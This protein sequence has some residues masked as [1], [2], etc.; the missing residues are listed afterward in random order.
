MKDK[1]KFSICVITKNESKTLPR[2]VKSLKEF[3]E[4]GGEIVVVDTG[5]TDNTAQLARDLGCTTYEVGTKFITVLDKQTAQDINTRFIVD[6]EEPVVA[7]GKKFFDFSAARNYCTSLAS[8]DV[9]SYADADEIFTAMNIDYLNHLIKVGVEQFE[10]NFVYAHDAYGN[11]AIKFIQ[12]KMYDRR[13]CKWV[14]M[15]HEVL[16]GEAHRTQLPEEMFKLEHYQIPSEHRGNYLSGLALDCFKNQD[17]DRNSHYFARE[18]MWCGRPKSAIKEFERHVA[19]NRWQTEKAQSII[20]I[21]DCCGMLRQPEKQVEY[22]NKAIYA[23]GSRREPYIKLA[24]FYKA[25]N[26]HLLTAVYAMAAT[27]IPWGSYYA[28]DK[29]MY[30]Q[31]P[32][33]LLYW[34]KGWLGDIKGAQEHL[35]EALKYQPHNPKFLEDTKYYFEYWDH[36]IQGYMKFPELLF[37][38]EEAKK[39]KT[40]VEIGSFQ[41]RS[42]HALC[43]G[44]KGVVTAVD[45]FEGSAEVHDGTHGMKGIYEI[46]KENTKGFDNL[47]VKKTDSLSGAKDFVDKSIDMVFIDAEHSYEAVKKDIEAWLPKTK[48]VLCGHDYCDA[49]PGVMRAVDEVFGKPDKVVDSIWVKYL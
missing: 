47:S 39:H 1:P 19:M 25:N 5:S 40:I 24:R 7:E 9:V 31:E 37:L 15:V 28:N 45:H 23:D 20:F 4:R 48:V 11:E 14:N 29:G 49:W 8:N 43:T 3:Q 46:F 22:Y 16:T 33:E 27:Q 2:L 26:N 12:S 18:L 32:H 35:L 34:A 10:Y 41:G 21:G 38:Y 42:T 6:G 36:G 17:N 30:E 13:K 44:T